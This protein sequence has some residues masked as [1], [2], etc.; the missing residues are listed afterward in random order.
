MTIRNRFL[1]LAAL[2]GASS[3]ALTGCVLPVGGGNGT[4]ETGNGTS[5]TDNGGTETENGGSD[6]GD[7]DVD[8]ANTEWTGEVKD[9]NGTSPVELLLNSDGTVDFIDFGGGG[10]IDHPGDTWSVDGDTVTISLVYE[11]AG[12]EYN[13]DMT[14][15]LNADRLELSEGGL[16]GMSIT[17]DRA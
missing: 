13:V 1:A 8:L 14:G 17:L 9:S 10:S 16:G 4:S 12:G 7:V 6:G 3:L 5:E 2:L 11:N 15:D